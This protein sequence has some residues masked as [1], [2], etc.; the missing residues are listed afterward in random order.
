M[1]F[2]VVDALQVGGEQ[3]DDQIAGLNR[4]RGKHIGH[5]GTAVQ[6]DEIHQLCGSV[7]QLEYHSIFDFRIA[8]RIFAGG[9]AHQ[10]D[11]GIAFEHR[12]M[13]CHQ[14]GVDFYAAQDLPHRGVGLDDLLRQPDRE[15]GD[16]DLRVDDD[17][18][19]LVAGQGFCQDAGK[20]TFPAP[21][22][23]PDSNDFSHRKLLS[24]G[25]N[26]LDFLQNKCII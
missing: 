4:R 7:D 22:A 16:A 14:R 8:Q 15:H 3:A 17:G 1:G 18:F 20:H 12:N 26:A 11:E 19:P 24:Q 21:R 5:V 9:I 23:A 6:D 25:R 13:A 2:Q 10:A